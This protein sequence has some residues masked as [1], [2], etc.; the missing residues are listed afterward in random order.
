MI[1]ERII[2]ATVM[3]VY[4]LIGNLV[5]LIFH[6]NA[7]GVGKISVGDYVKWQWF[8]PFPVLYVICTLIVSGARS[9]A[10]KARNEK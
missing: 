10:K 9:M 3:A 8:W 1:G 7:Y 5:L 4:F 6:T 2:G